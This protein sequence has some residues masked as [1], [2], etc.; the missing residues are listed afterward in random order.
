MNQTGNSLKVFAELTKSVDD[1][2]IISV[3]R[4]SKPFANLTA[5]YFY[6]LNENGTNNIYT[7]TSINYRNDAYIFDLNYTKNS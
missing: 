7:V 1:G 4:T 3:Y 2:N 5:C 6:R